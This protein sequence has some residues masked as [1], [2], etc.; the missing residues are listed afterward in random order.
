MWS[1]RPRQGEAHFDELVRMTIE[2]VVELSEVI[3]LARVHSNQRPSSPTPLA[4]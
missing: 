2:A 4:H 1:A 3:R